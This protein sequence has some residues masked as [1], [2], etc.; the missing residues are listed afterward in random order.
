MQVGFE[1]VCPDTPTSRTS[2]YDIP[3]TFLGRPNNSWRGDDQ[4]KHYSP[5]ISSKKTQHRMDCLNPILDCGAGHSRPS[6]CI[7]TLAKFDSSS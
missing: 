4:Q 2:S 7:M 3:G 6:V 5:T 1:E